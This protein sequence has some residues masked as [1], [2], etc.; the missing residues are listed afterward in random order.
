MSYGSSIHKTKHIDIHIYKLMCKN[1]SYINIKVY[2]M[3]PNL[4]ESLN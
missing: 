1:M 2:H 4:G 3:L